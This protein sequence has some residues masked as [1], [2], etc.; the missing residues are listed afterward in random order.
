MSILS[1]SKQRTP[2]DRRRIMAL[3]PIRNPH[4][5]WTPPVGP[6]PVI[7]RIPLQ[8]R[9][10]PKLLLWL[11]TKF[12]NRKPPDNRSLELDPVGSFVWRAVDGRT[13]VRQ[14]IWRMV[15][16]YKLN[17]KEAEVALL[18]FLRQLSSRNLIALGHIPADKG[19][20]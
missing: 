4:A 10:A 1:K 18:D 15:A 14:L 11:A 5:S 2:P 20:E 6:L 16:E 12:A 17:R 19:R 7:I 3:M 9:P 8:R 13:T